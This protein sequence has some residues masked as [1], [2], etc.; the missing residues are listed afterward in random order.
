MIATVIGA[1][2]ATYCCG[3][4]QGFRPTAEAIESSLTPRTRAVIINAPGNPTGT[5]AEPEELRRICALLDERGIPWV[6]DEIYDRFVYTSQPFCSPSN[7][8]RKGIVL[9]GLSKSANMMGW[10]LGWLAAPVEAVAGLTA[11]HQSV[12]TCA[13]TLAQAAALAV[14]EGLCGRGPALDVVER[15]VEVFGDRRRRALA[16]LDALG[17]RR[18]PAEGAFYAFVD[19][20][21]HLREGEDDLALCMRMLEEQR[22]IAIPGQ[23]FGEAGRGWVRLAYTTARVED[24]VRR[25]GEALGL[26]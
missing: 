3:A 19:V 23:G 26:R 24:G 20:R 17:L 12:C 11:V 22:V 9:S 18:A 16:A 1:T 25:F 6:S 21:P 15:N 7:F 2:T 13:S 8:S 5:L 4:G 10:R 14:V